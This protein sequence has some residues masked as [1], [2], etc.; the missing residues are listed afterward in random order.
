MDKTLVPGGAADGERAADLAQALKPVLGKL[1]DLIAA[2]LL[3]SL[4]P[5]RII[6]FA[7]F[8]TLVRMHLPFAATD[9]IQRHILTRQGFYEAPLLAQMRGLIRPGAVVVDIG[10]NIGNH[11]LFFAMICGAGMVH[12]FEPMRLTFG[13]LQRNAALNG[14]S[15][16]RCVNAGLGAEEGRAALLAWPANNI[17]AA[18][19]AATA[20]G[21][22]GAGGYAVTTLDAQ[23]LDRVD[24][25]KIDV[26]GT[27]LAVL[28][29]ARET[30]LRHRPPVWL[31]LRPGQGEL[32]PGDA[33]MRGLGYRRTRALSRNDYLY[34]AGG[35]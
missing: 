10:A 11:A 7:A 28:D 9:V 12:A 31:E 1:D 15:N 32:E 27:H 34:E 18:R 30:L 4:G 13:L 3:Q 6:E 25:V 19:L 21:G 8:D 20:G 14:L 23:R 35:G 17:G 2:T 33:A 29:G 22:G 24:F 5:E 26:E 16:L